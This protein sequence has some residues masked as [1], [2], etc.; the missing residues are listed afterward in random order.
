MTMTRTVLKNY[1]PTPRS[2]FL[3]AASVLQADKNLTEF[4]MQHSK[5]GIALLY[6]AGAS[7]LAFGL[8]YIYI[9]F[10]SGLMLYHIKFLGM[11]CDELPANVCALMKTFVQII[12]CAFTSIAISCL[13]ITRAM[14]QGKIGPIGLKII[15]ITFLLLVPIIPIMMHLATYT[16]WYLVV[17]I[18]LVAFTGLMLSRPK[19]N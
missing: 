8:L 12:G 13:Y 10:T 2:S 14:T 9:G 4:F 5:T 3:P 6:L 1:C 18:L 15:A 16:P 11:T 19:Q 17:A 7:I